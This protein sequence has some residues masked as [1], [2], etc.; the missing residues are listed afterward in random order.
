MKLKNITEETHQV[1][2]PET[3][4]ISTRTVTTSKTFSAKVSEEKFYITYIS[5]L[6]SL[7]NLFST[8]DRAV[9]DVLNTWSEFDSGIVFLPTERRN[10]L[11]EKVGIKPQT[12]SNSLQGLKKKGIIALK[13]GMVT[14]NPNFFWKGDLKVR[15]SLLKNQEV[16]ITFGMFDPTNR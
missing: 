14:I 13:R 6:D 1:V 8:T 16:F 11:A 15:N 5:A 7:L 10:Q 3:G 9:L 2:D 12:L 4:E